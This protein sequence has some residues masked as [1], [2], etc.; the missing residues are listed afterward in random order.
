[1]K[2]IILQSYFKLFEYFLSRRDFSHPGSVLDFVSRRPKCASVPS[3]L[4]SVLLAAERLGS[5][6]R[7]AAIFI[8]FS[9]SVLFRGARADSHAKV[10]SGLDFLSSAADFS[11]LVS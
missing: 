8:S 9:F 11:S 2:K 5:S 7:A 6:V 10:N 1:M 4:R 3:Q